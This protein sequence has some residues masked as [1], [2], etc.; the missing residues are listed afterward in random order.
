V[1]DPHENPLTPDQTDHLVEAN[2][3]YDRGDFDG[4]RSLA[5]KMLAQLPGNVRMLRVV[6][7]SAC[8]MGDHD[9]AQKYASELPPPDHEA[10]VAR[11]AKYEI[12]LKP[13]S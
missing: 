2:K 12:A 5:K 1:T 6:V 7:S 8:I 11:C 13:R 4:A 10:M 3:L 9:E